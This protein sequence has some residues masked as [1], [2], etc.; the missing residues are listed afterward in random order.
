MLQFFCERRFYLNT[1]K[2]ASVVA[3][4]IFTCVLAS[5]ADREA[6][7][8]RY[9]AIIKEDPFNNLPPVE[10]LPPPEPPP[11]PEQPEIF[12]I[13]PGLDTIKVTLLSRYN[14]IPAAGFSDQQTQAS[15]YLLEGQK[16]EEFELLDVDLEKAVITLKR[17]GY[18]MELPLWINP[19]TTNKADVATFGMAAGSGAYAGVPLPA[20]SATAGTRGRVNTHVLSPEAQKRRDEVNARREAARK[21]REEARKKQQEELEKMTPE[22]REQRLHDINVDIII[23]N[24][25]PPLPIEL[26]ESDLKKLAEAGFDVPGVEGDT[27][28]PAEEASDDTATEQPPT[29]APE[30]KQATI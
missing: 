25:G 17:G 30:A 4:A 8:E 18:E 28:P 11:E 16:F 26:N 5:A 24:Q 22:E 1:G 23:N 2:T 7:F 29:P 10:Q 3:L 6:L 20:T 13:P 21:E 15:Y 14:G 12:V 9:N 27:P 19:A